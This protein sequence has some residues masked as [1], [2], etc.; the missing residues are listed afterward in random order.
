MINLIS[1]RLQCRNKL[2]DS[3]DSSN[4]QYDI[5]LC[6]LQGEQQKWLPTHPS[7]GF[8]SSW[9]LV[10][11]LIHHS[12]QVSIFQTLK[13][14]YRHFSTFTLSRQN[15]RTTLKFFCRKFTGTREA[16]HYVQ[17][18]LI[19]CLRCKHSVP[20]SQFSLWWW[21]WLLEVASSDVW[22]PS[23]DALPTQT[24]TST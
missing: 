22:L 16:F 12:E 24:V 2:K 23:V 9:L 7:T 8:W 10:F 19:Y 20:T 4:C 17:I 13:A 3:S 1:L 21:L 14:I 11:I 15:T 18:V 6:K 5:Y